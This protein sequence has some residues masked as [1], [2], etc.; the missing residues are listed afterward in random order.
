MEKLN[1]NY[2][3]SDIYIY[4]IASYTLNVYYF[5]VWMND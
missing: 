4:T 5:L 1:N 2:F 3:I